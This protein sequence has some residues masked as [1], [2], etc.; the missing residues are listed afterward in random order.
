MVFGK[1][2]EFHRS[3]MERYKEEEDLEPW[4]K[5]VMELHERAAFLFYFDA[6]MEETDRRILKEGKSR[7]E[8]LRVQGELVKGNLAPGSLLFLYTGEGVLMGAG[9][10]LTEPEEKEQGRKG[11]LRRRRNEFA[12]RL[13]Q[14]GD[15]DVPS[16]EKKEHSRMIRSLYQDLSLIAD[17]EMK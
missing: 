9:I 6:F 2:K 16:M 1:L 5:R 14:Y 15:R 12:I 7:G 4:K 10:L 8:V 13:E 11:L 3:V 17:V